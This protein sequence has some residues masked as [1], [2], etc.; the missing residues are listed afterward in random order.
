MGPL[1]QPQGEV[2]NTTSK[3]MAAAVVTALVS[4][5]MAHP[6]IAAPVTKTMTID[7]TLATELVLEAI[8]CDNSTGNQITI[9]GSQNGLPA[10]YG[11]ATFKSPS[12]KASTPSD[13]VSML[14]SA[15][16]GTTLEKRGVDSGVGGNPWIYIT[17]NGT[18]TLLGRCV[19][20]FK[21]NWKLNRTVT[22]PVTTVSQATECSVSGSAVN[23]DAS[24]TD[25]VG[26]DV[27]VTFDSKSPDNAKTPH[28]HK[29]SKSIKFTLTSTGGYVMGGKHRGIGGNPDVYFSIGTATPVSSTPVYLGRCRSLL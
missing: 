22:L 18:D 1:P 19:Q 13:D 15:G 23:N 14:L 20:G 4:F 5:A 25:A 9:W 16:N 26:T 28:P 8:N 6:A 10:V 21:A 12:G 7:A 3:K 2:M 17:Y 24:L 29:D 27:V 11:K